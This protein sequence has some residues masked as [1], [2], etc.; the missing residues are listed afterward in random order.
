M[1]WIALVPLGMAVVALTCSDTLW[2]W[3]AWSKRVEGIVGVERTPE[4][5][6]MRKVAAGFMIV[7]SVGLFFVARSIERDA[8]RAQDQFD[9]LWKELPPQEKPSAGPSAEPEE[10]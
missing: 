4:W 2:R 9:R 5:D 3:H 7:A 8:D 6:K 10:R 1:A